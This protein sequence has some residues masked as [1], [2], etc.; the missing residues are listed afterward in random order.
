MQKSIPDINLKYT[1]KY[2]KGKKSLL[3]ILCCYKYFLIS[4]MR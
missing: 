1:A 2:C 3:D 4:F